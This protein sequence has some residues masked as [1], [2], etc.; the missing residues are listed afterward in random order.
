MTAVIGVMLGG[1]LGGMLRMWV[2][3]RVAHYLGGHFP[4]GTLVINLSSALLLGVAFGV[5]NVQGSAPDTLGWGIL[6]A[7]L[8][9]G[10]S[11]VSSLS[12][13]VI[14]LWPQRPV[15]AVCYLLVSVTGGLVLVAAGHAMVQVMV[16]S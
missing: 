13:Q 6:A 1:A 8:L 3:N 15:S 11:T 16:E 10:Y 2:G 7:G 5:W 4:W 12:L 9:G 14:T